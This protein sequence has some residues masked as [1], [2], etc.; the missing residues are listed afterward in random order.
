MNK[1]TFKSV[2]LSFLTG[3]FGILTF[4]SC[5]EKKTEETS[6]QSAASFEFEI[7]DSLMVDYLGS[8]SWSD[9]SKDGKHIL[10]YD[11]QKKETLIFST[12][13]EVLGTFNKS[14]DQPDA[15]GGSPLSRPQFRNNQEWAILGKSGLFSFDL[16]GQ[17]LNTAKPEFPVTMSLL[18]SNADILHF[19]NKNEALVYF[20]GRDGEG[21]FY[22]NPSS[23]QLERANLENGKFSPTFPMPA[24]SKFGDIEKV[25]NVV[26]ATPALRIAENK[27]YLSFKNEPK[28]WVYDI[29]DLDNPLEEIDIQF[30]QFVEKDPIDA[31][32]FDKDNININAKDFSYGSINRI[33]IHEGMIILYYNSGVTTKQYDDIMEG[34]DNPSEGFNKIFQAN[35]AHYAILSKNGQLIPLEIPG[36]MQNIEFIDSE[37]NFWLSYNGEEE[38]DYELIF[39]AKLKAKK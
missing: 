2:S 27:L 13:G 18:I 9:I 35:K 8:M 24:S 19:V 28:L 25:N 3:I 32:T 26:T 10:A 11:Y 20:L 6:I 14:E 38:L 30:D 1:H 31:K 5:G 15:I 7:Q 21:S 12:D 16:N 37:G 39:K 29:N 33:F 36:R 4:Q 22:I 17:L 23:T 34:L